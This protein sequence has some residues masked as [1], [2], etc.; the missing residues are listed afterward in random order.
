MNLLRATLDGAGG[1]PAAR[2]GDLVLGL[3]GAASALAARRGAEIVLGIRPEHVHE[4]APLGLA[5]PN[6]ADARVA[7]VEPLGAETLL[8]LALAGGQE[9]VARVGGESR[10][11]RG[12]A[13]RIAIDPAAIQLFDAGSGA[14]LRGG[15]AAA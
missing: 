2:I 5:A 11:A 10:A 8:T 6:W 15:E 7:A 3:D 9:L 14:A 12:D 1:A 4:R 13:L